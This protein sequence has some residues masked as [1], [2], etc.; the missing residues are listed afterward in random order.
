MSALHY[1]ANAGHVDVLKLLIAA[2]AKVNIF[3]EVS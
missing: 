2:K 1:A 3:D